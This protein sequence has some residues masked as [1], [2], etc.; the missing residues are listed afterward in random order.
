MSTF[1]HLNNEVIKNYWLKVIL[2][3]P[4]TG[5]LTSIQTKGWK[6]IL[7]E[8]TPQNKTKQNKS[9]Q[10]CGTATIVSSHNLLELYLQSKGILKYFK[11]SE[12]IVH[13]YT[14]ISRIQ[15]IESIVMLKKRTISKAVMAL[16]KLKHV[17]F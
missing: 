13:V 12:Y 6:V 9:H 7:L 1:L 15:L 4:P 10:Y 2:P 16:K 3:F 8:I 5:L 17:Q 14:E 11:K